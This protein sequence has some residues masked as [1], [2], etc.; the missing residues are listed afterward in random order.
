[1]LF[2]SKKILII[3]VASHLKISKGKLGYLTW[4]SISMRKFVFLANT[5]LNKYSEVGIYKRKQEELAFFLVD[6]VVEILFSYFFF[7]GR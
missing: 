7:I 3:S 4:Q 2:H 1:M 6:A 5:F